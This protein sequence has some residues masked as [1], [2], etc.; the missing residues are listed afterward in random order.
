M[1]VFVMVFVV[2]FVVVVVVFVDIDGIIKLDGAASACFR[3]A[4]RNRPVTILVA[5]VLIGCDGEEKLG[6][7]VEVDC[8]VCCCCCCCCC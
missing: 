2:V 5:L 3:P 6:V 4:A 8:R 7:E 1:V